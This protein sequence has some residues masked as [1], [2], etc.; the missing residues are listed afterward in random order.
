MNFLQWLFSIRKTEGEWLPAD[1]LSFTFFLLSVMKMSARYLQY[2]YFVYLLE[3]KHCI[4]ESQPWK[5]VWLVASRASLSK[6]G[7]KSPASPKRGKK[8]FSFVSQSLSRASHNQRECVIFV[9]SISDHSC[10]FL[11]VSVQSWEVFLLVSCYIFSVT[12][13]QPLV[14][15]TASYKTEIRRKPLLTILSFKLNCYLLHSY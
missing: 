13:C 6:Y 11:L 15:W 3:L 4:I 10:I 2:A 5:F 8:N 12:L 14:Y 9:L 1:R 7:F